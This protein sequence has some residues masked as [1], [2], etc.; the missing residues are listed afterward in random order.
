MKKVIK[1]VQPILPDGDLILDQV[2]EISFYGK[3]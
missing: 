3:Y 1:G 2:R